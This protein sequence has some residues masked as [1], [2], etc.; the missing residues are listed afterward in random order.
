[1]FGTLQAV[2]LS[3]VRYFFWQYRDINILK[4]REKVVLV[5][6][7]TTYFISD[8]PSYPFTMVK[9]ATVEHI[10]FGLSVYFL[11]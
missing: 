6:K 3:L 2:I 7:S 9:T 11:H 5:I 8:I 10:G 4:Y 1:M